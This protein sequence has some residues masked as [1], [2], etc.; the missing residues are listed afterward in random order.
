MQRGSAE[1][2]QQVLDFVEKAKKH[3][4]EFIS[5][6]AAYIDIDSFIDYKVAEIYVANIDW[7]SNNIR[8]WRYS[9]SKKYP[10]TTSGYTDGRWRWLMYDLDEAGREADLNMLI[11]AIDKGAYSRS[12]PW[13]AFMLRSLLESPEFKQKFIT[14]YSDLINSTFLP[15]RMTRVIRATQADLAV[16][17]PRHIERWK[18]PQNIEAWHEEVDGL[19]DFFV[20]RPSYQ[21]QHLQEFFEL[22]ERYQV[23]VELSEPAS[24]ALQLNSLTLGASKSDENPVTATELRLPWQGEYFKNLPLE[25]HALPAPN[26]RFSHWEMEGLTSE[27]SRK[28]HLILQPQ[29]DLHIRAIMIAD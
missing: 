29:T 8:Y 26:Y 27:Q 14:R 9:G 16:E 7:P 15:E 25:L 1:H 13:A 24:G 19:A 18:Q 21:W 2:W 28:S 6:L 22:N 12:A 23:Q 10:L 3:S 17:M 20:K 11:Q 4:P 5:E